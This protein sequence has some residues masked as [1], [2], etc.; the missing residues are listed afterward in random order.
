[1]LFIL[2]L[3]ILF[4][5][6]QLQET[7]YEVM[8]YKVFKTGFES[9]SVLR[10][11]LPVYPDPHWEKQLDPDPQKMNADPQPW[12]KVNLEVLNLWEE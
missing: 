12:W 11:Q 5:F 10:K 2:F 3:S 1:M 7:L 4:Y 8:F 6:F 9:W